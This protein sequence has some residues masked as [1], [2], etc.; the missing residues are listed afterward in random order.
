MLNF[1]SKHVRHG[2]FIVCNLH[3]FLDLAVPL[4]EGELAA[5]PT[6]WRKKD[7]AGV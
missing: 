1:Q 2:Y 7:Y 3:I 6:I 5:G 4:V